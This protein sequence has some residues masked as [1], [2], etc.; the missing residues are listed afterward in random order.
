M[1]ENDGVVRNKEQMDR[2]RGV[3]S[4][5][6]QRSANTRDIKPTSLVAPVEKPLTAAQIP[7]DAMSIAMNPRGPNNRCGPTFFAQQSDLLAQQ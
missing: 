2:A 4:D 7:C 5:L 6:A 1:T 3:V